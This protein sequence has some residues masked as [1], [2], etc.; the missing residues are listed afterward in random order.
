MKYIVIVQIRLK[1]IYNK[2]LVPA[3]SW[4][5]FSRLK[6]KKTSIVK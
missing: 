2:E 3:L 5:I 4:N 6:K 1:I